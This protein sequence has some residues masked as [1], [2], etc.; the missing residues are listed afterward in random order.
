MPPVPSLIHRSAVLLPARQAPVGWLPGPPLPGLWCHSES[1][2]SQHLPR[3]T[4]RR[5]NSTSGA[6]HQRH[7]APTG[8]FVLHEAQDGRQKVLS[9][10][11]AG[12]RLRQNRSP[13]PALEQRQAALV[14]TNM[15]RP[16]L[17]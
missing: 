15:S 14:K 5:W 12:E 9:C 8:L 11:L 1:A 6:K 3:E 17:P 7:E 10:P 4:C 13:V 16:N 2:A